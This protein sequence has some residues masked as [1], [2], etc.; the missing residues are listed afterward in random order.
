MPIAVA[1]VMRFCESLAKRPALE[2]LSAMVLAP[3]ALL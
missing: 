3:F 1:A 2:I